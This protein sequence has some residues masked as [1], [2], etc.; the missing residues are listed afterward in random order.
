MRALRAIALLLGAG[1]GL[2]CSA[3]QSEV[4]SPVAARAAE[5]TAAATSPA[6]CQVTL[7]FQRPPDQV[8]DWAR[9]GASPAVTHEQAVQLAK[10]TN[11]A[12]ADGI[13]IAL[14]SDGRVTWGTPT[15]GSKFPVWVLGNGAVSAVA[16]RVDGPTPPG[17]TGRFNGDDPIGQGPGFNSSAITFPTNGC[18]EVTYRA[19]DATLRFVVEVAHS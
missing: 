14:P 13:W 10:D 4:P 17:V 7:A 2:A 18:W 19:G 9:S 3:P 12:G 8:I 5:P 15:F 11:W 6:N 1:A 16:R